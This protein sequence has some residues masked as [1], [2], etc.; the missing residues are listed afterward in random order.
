VPD[1]TRWS[2]R[3]TITANTNT[4]ANANANAN[5]VVAH[6]GAADRTGRGYAVRHG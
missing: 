6:A 3:L 2:K 4:N 5:G 1:S